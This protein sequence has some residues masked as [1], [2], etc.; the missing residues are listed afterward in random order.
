[1]T[2]ALARRAG[3]S[4]LKMPLPTKTPSTPICIIRAASAGVAIPPA[5]KFTTGSLPVRA[6][7]PADAA[8]GLTQGA[9]TADKGPLEGVLVDVVGLVGRGQHLGLVDVVDAEGL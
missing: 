5:A 2:M 1:M 3:S 4:L 9:A 7:S 6:T 8:Q